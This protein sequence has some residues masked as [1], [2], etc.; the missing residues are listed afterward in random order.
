MVY[1][2]LFIYRII[3]SSKEK[4]VQFVKMTYKWANEN[5]IS[6]VELIYVC[7]SFAIWGYSYAEKN[8]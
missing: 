3:Y 1:G 2:W 8:M 4:A 5:Y 7:C 6:K